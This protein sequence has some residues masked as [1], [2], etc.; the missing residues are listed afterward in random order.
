MTFDIYAYFNTEQLALLIDAIAAFTA[1]AGYLDLIKMVV[2]LG[3]IVLI[4]GLAL[5]KDQ[6]PFEF[7]RWLIA[8]TIITSV[9]LVP[10]VDVIILDRTGSSAPV[11]KSNVPI[12]FAFFASV[13]SHVG[14]YLTRSFE[15]IFALPTDLQFQKNGIMFGNTVLTETLKVGITDPVLQKDMLDFVNNCTYYDILA[16]RI[17]PITLSQ[18]DDIWAGLSNTSLTLR[19]PYASDP[20]GSMAC[21]D[22]Y[23][24]LTTRLAVEVNKQSTVLGRKLNPKAVN[25]AVAQTLLTSQISNSYATLT[26]ISKSSTEI[27]RQAMMANTIRSSQMA[28]AQRLNDASAAIVGS[29]QAEAEITA[30]TNYL[31]MARVAE[32]AAPAIRNAVEII[33]YAVFPIILVMLLVAP[34]QSGPI[35]K[36][37]ILTMLWVQIIP[38]LYA[39]LNFVM[40]SASYVKLRGIVDGYAATNVTLQS[41]GDLSQQGLSD[42]AI[43]GYLSLLVPAIAYAIIKTGEV[44]GA[45]LFTGAMSGASGAASS[46][47]SALTKGNIDQGLVNVDNQNMNNQNMNKSDTTPSVTSGFTRFTNA[48]GTTTTSTDGTTRRYQSN[49]SSLPIDASTGM[50]TANSLS[51]EASRLSDESNRLST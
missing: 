31:I 2:M 16:N 48:Q 15:T 8:V 41:I 30:T 50:K 40:V 32:R 28:S 6:D 26:T 9:L 11:A 24:A 4:A 35:L 27:L 51:S 34:V 1:S 37:Y 19:T 17:D 36:N 5:G 14:D 33:I 3:F 21:D 38:A 47:S 46:A 20:T 49:Q 39:V 45:A 23:T 42:M 22:A 25:N 13:T 10:K 29:G 43:G 18:T 7:F 12:G 44:G